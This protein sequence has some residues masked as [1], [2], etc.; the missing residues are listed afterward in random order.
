MAGEIPAMSLPAP[1]SAGAAPR[2]I[3][4]LVSVLAAAHILGMAYGWGWAT[5]RFD[6]AFE[7]PPGAVYPPGAAQQIF[8]DNDPCYWLTYAREIVETGRGRVRWTRADNTPQGRPVY[9]SQSVSWGLAGLG[10]LRR[11]VTGESWIEA[12]ERGALWLNPLVHVVFL[13]ITASFWRRRYGAAPALIW[14]VFCAGL[15]DLTWNFH[16]LRPDHHTLHLAALVGGLLA[17]LAGGLGWVR[18]GN[19]ATDLAR[20]AWFRAP[21]P[22]DRTTAR[23]GFAVAGLLTGVGLWVGATIVVFGLAALAGG[24]LV[25]AYSA[26]PG[27]EDRAQFEPSLWRRWGW[28][29]AATGF[30]FWLLEFAP[31]PFPLGRLEINHP[32]HWLFLL[33]LGETLTRLLSR[34]LLGQRAA[35]DRW[36]LP[37]GLLALAALPLA[38]FLGPTS[39]HAM[40]DPQMRRMHDFIMEFYTLP[41]FTGGAPLARV[42]RAAG[43]LPLAW[44]G[45]LLWLRPGRGDRA[46]AAAL[47]TVFA[48][49]L[50][51]AAMAYAQVRWMAVAAASLIAL[52]TLVVAIWGAS[53]Q[54]ARNRLGT[55]AALVALA[56]LP[57][58]HGV[59]EW[60]QIAMVG[61]RTRTI[62][63][64]M[65]ASLMKRLCA[66]LGAAAQAA[67][68]EWRF[69]CEPDLAGPLYYYGGI[70]SVTSFYWENLDGLRA[71]AAFMADRD[72][73]AETARRVAVERGLTHYMTPISPEIAI[74]FNYIATGTL[75]KEAAR[76]SFA[77][78]LLGSGRPVPEWTDLDNEL[79]AIGRSE[80]VF[81]SALG[82]VKVHTSLGI[83]RIETTETGTTVS[84]DR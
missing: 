20:D 12:L 67:G 4:R 81:H 2:W 23:R 8:L 7:S 42:L 24:L 48:F 3:F 57:V 84:G 43:P 28:W 72:S 68:G 49:S 17:L 13:W 16:A 34:R 40:R 29:S 55:A 64:F 5:R 46:Q 63:A 26:K 35:S 61:G 59:H 47:W 14:L 9:W 31:G 37:L 54:A 38:V 50:F 21:A 15:S 62:D 78:G 71:A 53:P 60:R 22:P 41:H 82:P 39:W 77:A 1:H 25:L 19:A 75:S 79:T 45:A 56:A 80:Y 36:A 44:L 70:P 27:M 11:A 51:F 65:K 66:R 32:L 10:A 52:A 30:A 69:L 76:D 73:A 58:W 33:G 6:A 74:I 83:Y 18:E